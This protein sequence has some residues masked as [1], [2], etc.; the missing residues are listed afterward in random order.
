MYLERHSGLLVG[1]A[2]YT[3]G[4]ATCGLSFRQRCAKHTHSLSLL[5]WTAFVVQWN[6]EK[7]FHYFHGKIWNFLIILTFCI[8]AFKNRWKGGSIYHIIPQNDCDIRFCMRNWVVISEASHPW[9]RRSQYPMHAQRYEN[10]F[11]RALTA[12]ISKHSLCALYCH[13]WH[14]SDFRQMVNILLLYFLGEWQFVRV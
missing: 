10:E 13:R 14:L 5:S 12:Q 9:R 4:F 2:D 6:S 3:M 1:G 7:T 8:D 11:E